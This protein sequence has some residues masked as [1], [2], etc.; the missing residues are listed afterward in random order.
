MDSATVASTMEAVSMGEEAASAARH[1]GEADFT[2]VA[3]ATAEAIVE[4]GLPVRTGCHPAGVASPL[5]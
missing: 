3:A 4:R 2:E 5:L 1:M